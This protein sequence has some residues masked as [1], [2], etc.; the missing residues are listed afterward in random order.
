MSTENKA[1]ISPNLLFEVSWE[2][3]N[4]VGGIHTVV[5]TKALSINKMLGDNYILI[6]P[7]IHHEAENQE[8]EEDKTLFPVWAKMVY[9]LGLRIKIGRW[10]IKGSPIVVLVDFSSL[11][12][13]KDEILSFMWEQYKVD[14]ISG[15]WDYIEPVL[16][17][18]AAGKIIESYLENF[19]H[20]SDNV[21]AHFHEW[22]T[23]SGGLYLK[24]KV[25]YV[26]NVF[27]THATVMGRS[28]AGNNVPLYGS[29]KTIS[30]DD[31]ARDFNVVAK[32]S[33]EKTAAKSADCFATVSDI[34]SDECTYLLQQPVSQVT[35]NGFEDDFVPKGA[36]LES[37]R[38]ASRALMLRVAEACLG[39]SYK[40]EP[41]IVGSSGRY[42]F[43]NK[44]LDVF[45]DSLNKLAQN[46]KLKKEI[47]AYITVPAGNN[48]PRH[49]LKAHL[50]NPNNPIDP[51]LFK[52]T[53]HY[54]SA[55]DWDPIYRRMQGTKLMDA[56]SK[57][58]VIFVPTYLDGNDGIFNMPYYDLLLGMDVTVYASYYEPWGY[59]PLESVAFSVPTITTTLAGFGLW[60]DAHKAEH[61]GVDVIKR[62]D[63]NNQEV[64][65]SI[66]AALERYV[67]MSAKDFAAA[68]V[69]AQEISQIARWDNLVDYYMKA[70]D[71]ALNTAQE[72]CS[73][74]HYEGG[75]DRTEQIN[76]LRQQLSN[77]TPTWKRM[78]VEK[79]LP[80]RLLP[81]AKLSRNL[82]W[83]WTLAAQE[84]FEYIDLDLYNA[85]DRNPIEM[86]DKI[87]PR[88]M[89]EL[90]EDKY[91]LSKMDAVYKT[92][93]DYMAEKH[94][95]KSPKIAYFC[96]EYG[97]INSLKIYSG[98]LGIL[99][100]DYVKEASDKN[101]PMVAIGLLYR[102]GYF[103]QR[104]SSQGAQ[105]AGYEAQ[106]F[107]KLP[108]SPVRD[109]NGEWISVNIG[110]PGRTVVAKLWRCDVGRTEL[111]L[112]D[113]DH[114]LNLEEDRSITHHLY[115]GDWENRIK[116]EI[117]LGVGG[118]RALNALGI[119]Q[120]VYHC[121]EGHAA[122]MG[123]ER[124]NNLVNTD[125]LSF[126]EALEVVRSSSLFTTH[127]PVPAGHDAFPESMMRQ[128]MSHYP[129]R[130]AI[131]W[132]QFINLGKTN[133]YN[134]DEKFSM[135][136]L[137]ANLSQE[138]N[139]VSWLHGEVSKDI[140]GDM[141][142]G[143]FKDELHIGYVTNGVHFPTWTAPIMRNLYAKYFPEGFNDKT[144]NINAWAKAKNIDDNE[145]WDARMTLK[146][147]LVNEIKKRVA[148]P[149]QIVFDAPRQMVKLS[150]SFKPD[151]L[152]IGF[153][154]RF[155]TY[156]RAHLLFTNLERLSRIVNNPERPVQFV[157][158]G[159]AHPN[160][161]PGQD[162]IKRIVEISAMPEFVGKIIFLQNYDIQLARRMVQGVDIWMNTPTRPLEAS[163]TS[164]EKAVMNGVM[165]FSVL[166]GWW[167]EGYKPGA[168]WMLPLERTFENQDF[169][170]QMDAEMIYRI[171][172]SEIAPRYYDR[173]SSNIP[174]KW[175][176]TIKLC[177]SDVAS[178]FTTN[179]MLVD[180][181]ER[182]Y[183]KLYKRNQ[184]VISSDFRQAREVAAWKRKVSNAWD[185]VKI[186]SVEQFDVAKS[187]IIVGDSYHIEVALEIANLRSEDIG[188]E[189]LIADQID[190]GNVRIVANRELEFVGMKND[191]AIFSINSEPDTTGTY[192]IA[193]RV[194]P[195]NDKLPH[196]MD[197][198]LVKWA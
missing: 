96:M 55:Q 29:M 113:T 94:D 81:L 137:A 188:V 150:E 117:I 194:F 99:A 198:A 189:L 60:V 128:Y 118:V 54:L 61:K 85:C 102:Y 56:D 82:W 123:L 145:L 63:D 195:K 68:R 164:G 1:L 161:K 40:K 11:F 76:F 109:E 7:D 163:G 50:E 136:V 126:S 39:V 148:D 146:Q 155:A 67:K 111:Y 23:S 5:A 58:K 122:F 52:T 46:D 167:V 49:D 69:S 132:D 3:C 101:V 197:F 86:L 140:M 120:D 156:K 83:S 149:T 127:T 131:T 190:G 112:L 89:K 93:E 32:H 33:L 103:T 66:A 177:I 15:Q 119:E 139:G 115:G 121:N 45:I 166:D 53:T 57:V 65:D 79:P 27:T 124:I 88:R 116:Q 192:D 160:D 18:Y 95:A 176:E 59:T 158:A 144:Y 154:R 90:Q 77:S 70:Y 135:S 114:D 138:V 191:K 78:M 48:G 36:E 10:K 165:H 38:K 35:P 143:Y 43:T 8:F 129:D 169:Q 162:L 64:V 74:M 34:T 41:L 80:E 25:P 100:G 92:F 186:C 173:N 87:S 141:W 168:G 12:A 196:R 151:V 183:N 142:P 125:K 107:D 17:G 30:A 91:F 108:I 171:I 180:Y 134:H 16:F 152:T 4:K 182:F 153:A 62:T 133:P 98:G 9:S 26:A 130:L 172:E 175:L 106:N 42:E 193:I 97:M 14:S 179:R 174:T 157:F 31:Y 84:V 44:G 73:G 51:N 21:V 184:A 19:S 72:R 181:E 75:G 2:V 47:L 110:M 13:K 178:N 22:M 170:N 20:A 28:L 147:K 105:E 6:G 187:A 37:K 185:N 104:L 24:A 71:T 159:K